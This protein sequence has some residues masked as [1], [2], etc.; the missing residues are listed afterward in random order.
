MKVSSIKLNNFKRFSNLLIKDIPSNTKLVIIVGSNGSGKSSLFD[1][2]NTWYRSHSGF[3]MNQDDSY[4]KKHHDKSFNH[5]SDVD[6]KFHDHSDGVNVEKKSM[7]FR[8][9][10]RNDPDFNISNF[11]KVNAPHEQLKVSRFIDNDQTVSENYQRLV[12]NTMSGVYSE[13]NDAKN[14]KELREELIGKIRTSML[15]V[16]D[17]LVLNNIGNPLGDGSFFF[18]KGEIDS[19]HYKN[20]SGGEKAAFDLLLDLNIKIEHYDNSIFFIDEPETHMHTALQ[21]KLVK[22]MYRVI[23]DNSQM[24]ITTHSL[25]V[26]KM[27]KQLS[28]NAP[29]SVAFIDFSEIDFDNDAEITPASIDGILWDKFL[30]IALDDFQ[31][32]IS[33]DV[34]IM[35][36]GD[37]NGVTRKNFDA[38]IYKKIFSKK[39][40][41]LAF[42]S[43][44]ACTDIEKDDHVGFKLLQEVL[45]ST[46]K[47]FRL[48]DRD[49]KSD[50][51]VDELKNKKI[52]VTCRR[53]LE[54]Y[55]LDD[56]LIKKLVLHNYR[57]DLISDAEK[58]DDQKKEELIALALKV[59]N[60]A[61]T[62]SIIR[63]RPEDDI[64]SASGEFYVEIRKLLKLTRCGND[65]DMFMMNTMAKFLTE[66]TNVFVEMEQNIIS[67]ILQEI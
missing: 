66:D 34:L 61:L 2:F 54:S 23:P 7:Y 31:N 11:S 19:Y 49:D 32:N 24:W 6:V 27:A 64:K 28:Q 12:H 14:V 15:N 43:G 36:E 51:E 8:T 48:L 60:D 10:Y 5:H 55:L 41:Q 63:G 47:I 58:N 44:G 59:K 25:G 26:M 29:E 37:I 67:K 42:I 50:E 13:S 65:A 56:E 35:C 52:Y 38:T 53:H 9:A 20:L 46:T 17:G 21:G 4:Y 1:A 57:S 16:F 40:P 22:E 18:K 39:Y 3:G 33:P 62:N 30:S 45:K